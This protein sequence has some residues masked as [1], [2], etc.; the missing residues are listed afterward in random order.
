MPNGPRKSPTARPRCAFCAPTKEYNIDL[1]Q[2]GVLGQFGGRASRRAGRCERREI[3]VGEHL[4]QSSA[5]RCAVDMFGPDRKTLK[6]CR[7]AEDPNSPEA[8]MWGKTLHRRRRTAREA[9]PLTYLSKDSPP[10]LIFHGDATRSSPSAEPPFPRRPAK[11]RL[12][13]RVHHAARRGH[14]HVAVGRKNANASTR[15]FDQYLKSEPPTNSKTD[16]S[17]RRP[18]TVIS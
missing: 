11:G 13:Q 16:Q 4:A 10:F 9:C 18:K 6:K 17:H 2:I 7:C 8:R 1:V 3:D 12:D 15:F 5:V 14:S